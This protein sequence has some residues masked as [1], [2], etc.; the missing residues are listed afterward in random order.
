MM[1]LVDSS[2]LL[3][4]TAIPGK[5]ISTKCDHIRACYLWSFQPNKNKK[6][7]VLINNISLC[8]TF[9]KSRCKQKLWLYGVSLNFQNVSWWGLQLGFCF[10]RHKC[11]I[12]ILK[13][14]GFFCITIFCV[15]CKVEQQFYLCGYIS[16]ESQTS[17]TKLIV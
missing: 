15:I 5:V 14:H 6:Q 4:Y 10:R 7:S 17:T 12:E 3:D 9:T 16:E 8:I 1:G 11:L 13:L 2:C